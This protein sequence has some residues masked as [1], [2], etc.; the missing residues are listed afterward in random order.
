METEFKN[1]VPLET[2]DNYG[3]KV[4]LGTAINLLFQLLGPVSLS[5]QY[6]KNYI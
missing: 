4:A 2:G 3:Q 6:R 5:L 1:W